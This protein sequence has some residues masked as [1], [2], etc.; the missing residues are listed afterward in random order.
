MSDIMN[1]Q[2]E[3]VGNPRPPYQ[4]APMTRDSSQH[5]LK[6]TAEE[7]GKGHTDNTYDS[8]EEKAL[9]A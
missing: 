5:K 2:N 7:G 3:A 6:S 8:D 1:G 9:I 4:Y